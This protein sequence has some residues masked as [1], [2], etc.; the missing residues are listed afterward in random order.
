MCCKHYYHQNEKMEEYSINLKTHEHQYSSMERV[1]LTYTFLLIIILYAHTGKRMR[2]PWHAQ[3]RNYGLDCAGCSCFCRPRGS[4]L[5]T[6]IAQQ[7]LQHR[8]L[9]SFDLRLFR[10]YLE[11]A[12][13]NGTVHTICSNSQFGR[14]KQPTT[15]LSARCGRKR[16]DIIIWKPKCYR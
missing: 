1:T 12:W 7:T 3:V 16:N 9:D 4:S 14:D 5:A 8:V 13:A 10:K 2:E 11:Y 15:A 6:F